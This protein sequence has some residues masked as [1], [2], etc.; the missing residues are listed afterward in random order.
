MLGVLEDN[1]LKAMERLIQHG[2]VAAT[3]DGQ[4]ARAAFKELQDN[5]KLVSAGMKRSQGH[6]GR[7][8]PSSKYV[9]TLPLD[10]QNELRRL[11]HLP[12]LPESRQP[13]R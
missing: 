7:R 5:R 8:V 4:K 6:Y 3:S 11:C 1:D 10:R 12:L 9:S 13:P 2:F